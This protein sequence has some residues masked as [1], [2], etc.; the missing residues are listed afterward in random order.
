MTT[1]RQD[2]EGMG[3]LM[4]RLLMRLLNEA[5]GDAPASVITPTTL[6]R[7]ASA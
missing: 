4:V 1:V 7:R 6:V 2:V 3:R 5:G